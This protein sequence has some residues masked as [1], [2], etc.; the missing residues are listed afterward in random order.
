MTIHTLNPTTTTL[1]V[2]TRR[3]PYDAIRPGDTIVLNGGT[4]ARLIF[5]LVRGLMDAPVTVVNNDAV[6]VDTRHLGTNAVQFDFCEH[7]RFLGNEDSNHGERGIQLRGGSHAL[8]FLARSRQIETGYLHITESK[9]NA[10][11]TVNPLG[12]TEATWPY[13]AIA[14]FPKHPEF[15]ADGWEI[16]H[17]LIEN[18]PGSVGGI[19]VKTELISEGMYLGYN[20][21][22]WNSPTEPVPRCNGWDVHDNWCRFCRWESIQFTSTDERDPRGKVH[23]NYLE[24]DSL[25]VD[26]PGQVGSIRLKP[27]AD[28][29]VFCNVIWNGRARGLMFSGNPAGKGLS[30]AWNNII[31]NPCQDESFIN[32]GG[33]T[34]LGRERLELSHNTIV[35]PGPEADRGIALSGCD[36]VQ[37]LNN[38]VVGAKQ[39]YV[40]GTGTHTVSPSEGS[41]SFDYSL[42]LRFAQT[43]RPFDDDY[44]ALGPDSIAINVSSVDAMVGADIRGMPRPQGSMYDLGAYEAPII[45]VP[46]VEPPIEVT[47]PEP[48][49]PAANGPQPAAPITVQVE[50]ELT[51]TRVED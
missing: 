47:E 42:A 33:I 15:V 18:P 3:P 45:V 19:G 29:D 20:L 6:V 23:H 30:R 32:G 40:L 14:P 51:V 44:Y 1:T 31:I 5:K 49:P 12:Y 4:Y 36:G 41:T 22:D 7:V 8:R 9:G 46:P 35:N 25:A 34:A 27:A 10:G 37:L 2:D 50:G 16:H 26:D 21:V 43:D 28:L 48:I 38:L 39:P 24:G 13:G 17:M 11:I